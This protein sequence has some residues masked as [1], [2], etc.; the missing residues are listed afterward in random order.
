MFPQARFATFI[1]MNP[2]RILDALE[3]H[4]RASQPLDAIY[5]NNPNPTTADR[6]AYYERQERAEALR[7]LFDTT[8]S[9]AKHI[10]DQ[11]PDTLQVRVPDPTSTNSAIV[12]PLCRMSHDL[13]NVL[14]VIVGCSEMLADFPLEAE[15]IKFV[16]QIR[17]AA[18]RAAT[19]VRTTTCRIGEISKPQSKL[20]Q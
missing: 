11:K 18:M 13:K 3:T 9:A 14:H 2:D 12:Q 5:Y 20:T 10:K 17:V 15:A 16:D 4:L 19:I 8:S 7:N 6:T 1:R